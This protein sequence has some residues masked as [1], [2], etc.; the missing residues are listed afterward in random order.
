ML[1]TCVYYIIIIHTHIIHTYIHSHFL[2]CPG[3]LFIDKP[4]CHA[5][6]RARYVAPIVYNWPQASYEQWKDSGH[7]NVVSVAV[8]LRQITS[9]VQTI[10]CM[11][12][13]SSKQFNAHTHTY[14]ATYIRS[15]I[16]TYVCM[17]IIV[18]V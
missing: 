6:K 15:Y 2:L 10:I 13:V 8:G 1:M 17:Y 7:T 12:L 18:C 3:K 5:C 14:V 9:T 11:K 4:Q 16:R